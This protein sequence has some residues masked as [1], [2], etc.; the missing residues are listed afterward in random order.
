MTR[1][2]VAPTVGRVRGVPG[3]T[4]F[5]LVLDYL[6]KQHLSYSGRLAEREDSRSP[7]TVGC[8]SSRRT[9]GRRSG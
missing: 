1:D 4:D 5:S 2:H 7:D 6:S 3:A 8:S 9:R